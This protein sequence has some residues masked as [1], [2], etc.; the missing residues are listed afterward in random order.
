MNLDLSNEMTLRRVSDVFVTFLYG[1][2]IET[3][4]HHAVKVNPILI[5]N[6]DSNLGLQEPLTTG[7]SFL[8]LLLIIFIFS[9]WVSR[10][11]LPWLLPS[12]DEI[13]IGKQFLK[14]L[15]ELSGLFFLVL[16]WLHIIEHPSQDNALGLAPTFV[17]FW[18]HPLNQYRAFAIFLFATFFWNLLL[19]KVMQRIAWLELARMGLN[20]RALDS[21]K[22][23]EYASRLW[24]W[25]EP[26]K[27]LVERNAANGAIDHTGNNILIA[28]PLTIIEAL[29]RIGTLMVALHIAWA[30][31]FAGI[32]ILGGDIFFQHEPIGTGIIDKLRELQLDYLFFGLISSFIVFL[33]TAALIHHARQKQSSRNPLRLFLRHTRLIRLYYM[34]GGPLHLKKRVKRIFHNSHIFFIVNTL[35]IVG[36]F[37]FVSFSI[38]T[39]HYLSQY[40]LSLKAVI[41]A[42]CLLIVIG[43]FSWATFVSKEGMFRKLLLWGGGFTVTV[44]LLIIYLSLD[45]TSLMI[46]IAIQQVGI[47]AFLQ[48]AAS[49]N[50]AI[51]TMTP[52]TVVLAPGAIQQFT[53]N[54]Q[55]DFV[56]GT[57]GT[58]NGSISSDG[59]YTA[60]TNAGTETVRVWF[61]VNIGRFAEATIVVS[62]NIL[63]TDNLDGN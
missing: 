15:L 50:R 21:R 46:L 37:S 38:F 48:Y 1:A 45:T 11:R 43:S 51:L 16:A 3:I 17:E 60:P 9:D 23:E 14:S 62:D 31:L 10:V 47:T 8:V 61:G 49:E 19:L 57:W 4:I 2:S 24:Q 27:A 25:L 55:N 39:C 40:S 36:F 12:G 6:P 32:L 56:D 33:S 28:L 44:S 41:V 20:G 54:T 35:R 5:K 63:T 26:L 58:N 7:F 52:Q 34:K 30:S 29:A 18:H 59:L 13:K 53:V 42:G 22:V